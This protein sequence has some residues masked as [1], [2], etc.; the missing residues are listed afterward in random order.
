LARERKVSAADLRR[1]Y[2]HAHTLALAARARAG[3]DL[4]AHHPRNGRQKLARLD[5]LDWSRGNAALW[6]GRAMNAGRLSKK[7]V[8][9][10]LTGNAVKKH[11]GLGFSPEEEELEADFLRSRHGRD[12]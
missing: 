6:E 3:C 8:N 5:S 7:S 1:D 12:R 10:V 4:L 11:L 9:Q 2:I